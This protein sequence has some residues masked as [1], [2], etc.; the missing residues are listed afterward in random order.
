ME[1]R[2]SAV[3]LVAALAAACCASAASAQGVGRLEIHA[4]PSVTVSNQQFLS[5]AIAMENR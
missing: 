2:H 1:I 4:I 5:P 3:R